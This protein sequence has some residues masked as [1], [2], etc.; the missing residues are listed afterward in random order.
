V[1][2]DPSQHHGSGGPGREFT[3]G[4]VAG[5]AGT[6]PSR[7]RYYEARGVRRALEICGERDCQ[8]IDVCRMLDPGLTST[9]LEVQPSAPTSPK[10]ARRVSG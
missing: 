1:S 7:I 4:Q 3:I 9:R 6:S 5:R 8:S 10:V 2:A